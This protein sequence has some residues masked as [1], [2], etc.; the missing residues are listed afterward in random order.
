MWPNRPR[1]AALPTGP[2]QKGM[3]G[4]GSHDGTSSSGDSSQH[5]RCPLTMRYLGERPGLWHP[6]DPSGAG[7]EPR[8]PSGIAALGKAASQGGRPAALDM[9]AADPAQR[10]GS[11]MPQGCH[12]VALSKTGF[13]AQLPGAPA[14]WAAQTESPP[15]G[16]ASF[17]SDRLGAALLCP[18]HLRSTEIQGL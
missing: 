1:L 6:A 2:A 5:G 18:G 9:G 11:S 8:V 16:T 15:S 4:M 13:G 17:F 12:P 3:L 10:A 7:P 14:L